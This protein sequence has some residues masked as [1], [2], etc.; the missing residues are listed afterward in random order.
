MERRGVLVEEGGLEIGDRRQ[1]EEKGREKK[2]NEE[3]RGRRLS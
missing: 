1:V 3:G 2:E